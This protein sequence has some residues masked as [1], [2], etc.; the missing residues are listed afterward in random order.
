MQGLT[1]SHLGVTLGQSLGQYVVVAGTVK[2]VQGE[3]V[4]GQRRPAD[5]S[6]ALDAADD[7][8]A[9]QHVHGRTSMP[10]PWWRWSSGGSA[11]WR[12]T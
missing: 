11:W 4:T 3:V 6:D 12:G 9:A 1:T 2:Y 7:L 10:A 5:A 8:P